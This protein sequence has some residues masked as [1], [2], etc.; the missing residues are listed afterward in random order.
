[1]LGFWCGLHIIEPQTTSNEQL[2]KLVAPAAALLTFV[3]EI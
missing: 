1:M 3:G 2:D